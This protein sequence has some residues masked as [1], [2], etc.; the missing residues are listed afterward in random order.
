MPRVAKTDAALT[1]WTASFTPARLA[2]LLFLLLFAAY[3]GVILG[4][5][6]FFNNDFGLFTYPVAYYIRESIWRGEIPLWNP[7][8]DCGLPFLAQWNTTVCYPLSW[9]YILFPLPWSLNYFCLGHLIIAGLGMYALA[10]RWTQNRFAASV[11][12]LAYGFNGLS[13]NCLMWTS[14]LAALAWL[15][16]TIL[17]AERAWREGGRQIIWGGMVASMQVLSGAPEIVLIT[18]LLIGTLWLTQLCTRSCRFGPSA[19]RLGTVALLVA[20]LTAIQ[21]LP[22]LELLRH[23]ARKSGWTEG[24]WSM[25]TWGWANFFVPLFRCSKSI[26]G[27]AYQIEQQ[28]TSSYYFGIGILALGLLAIWRVRESRL[29][30]LAAMAF[31][32]VILALGNH[33][34]LYPALQKICPPLGLVRYPIKFIVAITFALPVLAAFALKWLACA[35]PSSGRS[36]QRSLLW[37]GSICFVLISGVL[38][39]DHFFPHENESSS[40]TLRNG[41]QRV[42]FLAIIIGSLSFYF[43]LPQFSRSPWFGLAILVL[44]GLDVLTHAPSQNPTVTKRA[45]D[46]FPLEMSSVPRFGQSRAMITPRMQALLNRSAM[47]DPLAYYTGN[48]R[49]LFENCNLP[50]NVP[51]VN[52]FFSLYLKD[53]ARIK[54][55]L[56]NPTNFPSSLAD[57]LGVAHISSSDQFWKWLPRDSALP[58]ITTGQKPLFI[59]PEQTLTALASPEFNPR[60]TV[61]LPLETQHEI[62]ANPSSS[63]QITNSVF[64][65]QKIPLDVITAQ[66]TLLVI[67]QSFYPAWRAYVDG[68]PTK[69]WKAN[70]AFQSLEIPA[71]THHVLLKYQDNCFYFGAL[72][73]GITLLISVSLLLILRTRVKSVR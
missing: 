50:F 33:T 72:L 35:Q 23:C 69:I 53:E 71:G 8:S 52:G 15:P 61:Y 16:L 73:S 25:P 51:K 26:L 19:L 5:H 32:G 47:P 45:Y 10:F 20:G 1:D 11:A 40:L 70:Y 42:L 66:P 12:G 64:F 49:S 56:Y 59:S 65:A 21:V 39:F 6:S 36:P 22:F 9:F 55:L 57:F 28:W 48:R 67:A 44:F 68:V 17:F 13:L 29:R 24:A 18:W 58:L 2:F 54:S 37:A 3:P 31:L 62:S 30:W 38:L 4:T 27:P 60:E 34:F 46:A 7:L 41:L 14:N 63:A 43:R